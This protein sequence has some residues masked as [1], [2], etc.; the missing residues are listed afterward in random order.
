MTAQRS[1]ADGRSGRVSGQ[2]VAATSS[3]EAQEALATG[4]PEARISGAPHRRN[5]R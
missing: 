4:V 3:S 2:S 1:E 5:G